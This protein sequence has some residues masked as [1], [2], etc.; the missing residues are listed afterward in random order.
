MPP[1]PP[2]ELC[3]ECEGTGWVIV[4]DGGAGTARPC[5]CRK[6]ALGMKLMEA[7]GIPARYAGCSL[8][9]FVTSHP[10]RSARNQLLEARSTAERYVERFVDEGR[11]RESGLL[12]YGPAGVGKTHLAAAILKALIEDYRV[13]GRFIDFTTLIHQIQSTFDPGSPESKREVLDP[14]IRADVLVLDELGAQKPTAWVQDVLYLVINT[15]YTERRPT[16]F[17]TNYPLERPK[18]QV[19]ER[20]ES[21]D[22][23]ADP[24]GR[25]SRLPPLEERITAQ[26]VSRLFEMAR[27]VSLEGVSD[28]RKEVMAEQAR[29]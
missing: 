23:G 17:T 10:D 27:P 14:V 29:M 26:L 7:A 4:E 19:R 12:F 5:E 15:R 25:I 20:A 11:F 16:L 3:P 18:P 24:P 8:S 1:Q 22:R 6:R 28:H 21:L 2:E 13:R 9:S